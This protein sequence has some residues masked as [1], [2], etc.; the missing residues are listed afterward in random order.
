M[1]QYLDYNQGLFDFINSSPTAFHAVAKIR[2]L[3]HEHD[4]VEL[5]E[6]QYWNLEKGKS[7]FTI[8]EGAAIAAFSIGSEEEIVDGFRMIG[9]HGDSPCLQIKPQAEVSSSPYL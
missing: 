9:S 1:T 4:F 5:H 7:Y 6:N 8:R 2:S 3:F